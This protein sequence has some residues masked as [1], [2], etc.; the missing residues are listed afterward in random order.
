MYYGQVQLGMSMLNLQK[1]YFI[2]YCSFDKSML[3]F[4]VEYDYIFAKEMLFNVKKKYFEK[5]L[6][7][8]CKDNDY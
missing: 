4:E 2:I 6:H 7:F 3:V 5:M 8:V 1:C